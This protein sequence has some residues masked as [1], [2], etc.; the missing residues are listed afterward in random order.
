MPGHQA[1]IPA[2]TELIPPRVY[3]RILYIGIPHLPL[4][5][6]LAIRSWIGGPYHAVISSVPTLPM[7]TAFMLFAI[8]LSLKRYSPPKDSSDKRARIMDAG[9]VLV[10]TIVGS[11]IFFCLF[12]ITVILSA[13][14]ETSTSS[15]EIHLLGAL[16][17]TVILSSGGIVYSLKVQSRLG[18]VAES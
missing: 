10:F 17:A 13:Q 8:G 12:G 1:Q 3:W 2:Y 15:G 11:F 7:I 14:R 5:I 18:L 9:R 4:A 16:L 6:E